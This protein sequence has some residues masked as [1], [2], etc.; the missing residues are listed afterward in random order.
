MCLKILSSYS[1]KKR[2]VIIIKVVLVAPYE[3]WER[4]TPKIG[5]Q[6][7]TFGISSSKWQKHGYFLYKNVLKGVYALC[8]LFTSVLH[9]IIKS[10]G[11]G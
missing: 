1:K 2:K 7:G 5:T 6:E 3:S 9:F 4:T 8:R 10:Q 11:G